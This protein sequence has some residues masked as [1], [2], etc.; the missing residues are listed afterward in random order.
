MAVARNANV[1]QVFGL[2]K[3]SFVDIRISCAPP[4][5][6]FYIYLSAAGPIYLTKEPSIT[7]YW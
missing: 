3:I 5:T 1:G 4:W 7:F 2:P 6:F